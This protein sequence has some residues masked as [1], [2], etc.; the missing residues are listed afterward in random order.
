MRT[1]AHCTHKKTHSYQSARQNDRL[2]CD[3]EAN[4]MECC[5]RECSV[6]VLVEWM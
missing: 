3:D 6:D 2:H 4:V 5:L 1:P